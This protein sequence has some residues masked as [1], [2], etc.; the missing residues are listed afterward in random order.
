MKLYFD[1]T[2]KTRKNKNIK[3]IKIKQKQKQIKKDD[4]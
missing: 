1:F 3:K 2:H 4:L